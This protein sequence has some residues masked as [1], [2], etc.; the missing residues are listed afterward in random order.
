MAAGAEGWRW[1]SSLETLMQVFR[2]PRDV[3]SQ[4]LSIDESAAE[5]E[6]KAGRYARESRERLEES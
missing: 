4:A 3:R 1:G 6:E 2:S 5:R